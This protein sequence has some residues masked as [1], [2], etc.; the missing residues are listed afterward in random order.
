MSAFRIV[1]ALAA[2]IYGSHA[3]YDAFAV[4]GWDN[5]GL[6]A[7]VISMLWAES[8][9]AEVVV[10]FVI[11]PWL[12]RRIGVRGAAALAAIAGIVRWS[13]MGFTGSV[14]FLALVQPLHGLTFALLHLACMTVL[15][16][17]V[18]AGLGATAQALY[19]FAPAL[20]TA[21][22]IFLSGTL[23]ADFG[24][25]AFLSMAALCVIALP[26]AWYGLTDEAVSP[27]EA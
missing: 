19:A 14:L 6:D 20:V 4:I 3:L 21:I 2:L 8:V 26:L 18:P 10:F 22:L 16:A 25:A 5:A 17:V 24:S 11:G 9:A 1:I 23:Y 27:K 12:I 13:V 15:G 7:S